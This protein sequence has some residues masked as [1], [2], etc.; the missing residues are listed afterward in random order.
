MK[1]L[2]LGF[3]AAAAVAVPL[4]AA[5]EAS[6]QNRDFGRRDGYSYDRRDND[7]RDNDR[8][9]RRDNNRRG[10][11]YRNND[12]YDRRDNRGWDS[13]RYNGYNYNNRW[14]YGAP[15]VTYYSSPSYYPGYRAF[16]RGQYLPPYYRNSYVNDYG[17]YGLYAP[18]RGY[19]WNRAG[20]DYVLAALATGLILEVISG[21]NGW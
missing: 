9:D 13:Q 6:A 8:Y 17:R 12:R 3:A 11:N 14:Y 10:N 1:R 4:L 5:T 16:S 15:P 20:N 7:R 18:P 2:F 19:G 21:N